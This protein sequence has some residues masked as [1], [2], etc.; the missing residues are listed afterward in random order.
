MSGFDWFF[1]VLYYINLVMIILVTI[2]FLPQLL[3]Y[4]FCWLPRKH[5]RPSEDFHKIAIYIC[6]HDEAET[7]GHTV[8]YLLHGLDY[9]KDKYKVYVCAHN[10]KDDT[11]IKARNAG[12]TVYEYR[13]EN[14][15]HRIVAYALKYLLSRILQEDKE[16]EVFIR[17]DADN[18]PCKSFLKEMNNS[19]SAGCRIVRAYE[20]ATNMKQNVWTE[21]CS[22]FSIKDSRAQNNFRQFCHMSTLAPGPG[23]TCTRDVIEKMNGFDCDSSIEDVEFSMKRLFEGYKIYFNTDAIVYEDQPSSF[24]DTKNRMVRMGRA[25]NLVYFRHGWRMLVNFFRTGKPTY[26]DCLLQVQFNP[27][28]VICFTWF[29][30]YYVFY[31]IC[32]LIGMSGHPV[33]SDS[34]FTF[35]LY[36]LNNIFTLNPTANIV[37]TDVS[38][39]QLYASYLGQ[40]FLYNPIT[41]GAFGVWASSQAFYGLLNMA[42]MVILG[43]SL[44]CIFQSYIVLLLDHR[45]LGLPISLRGMWKGILLSPVYSLIYGFCNFLGLLVKPKWKIANRNMKA[46]DILLPVPEKPNKR[47]YL[48]I[49]EKELRKYSGAWWK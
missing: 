42:W 46:S 31:A 28:S 11:A 14:R 21:T 5:F 6:A 18:I 39:G 27:I 24:E 26:L 29:P 34:F 25:L 40:R 15:K 22:I 43:I 10:C 45:K 38:S 36:S 1:I 8:E 41:D 7:I 9:P 2:G 17:F 12:A 20:A 19:I 33:F 35:N 30:F 32:M 47:Q 13:D 49:K 23:M 37:F 16:S 3:Y 48:V 44:F 4:L